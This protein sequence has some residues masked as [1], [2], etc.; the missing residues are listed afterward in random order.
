MC[1]TPSTAN[2]RYERALLGQLDTCNFIVVTSASFSRSLQLLR[3]ILRLRPQ[4]SKAQFKQKPR[5]KLEPAQ[6]VEEIC[7]DYHKTALQRFQAEQ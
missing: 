6:D 7:S 1:R 4:L 5:Q 3:T 2:K